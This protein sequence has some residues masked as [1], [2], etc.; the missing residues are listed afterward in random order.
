M[1][2]SRRNFLAGGAA[3]PALRQAAP[4]APRIGVVDV[5]ACFEKDRYSRM[6]ESL[7]EL[8][9]QRDLLQKEADELQ[10]RIAGLTEQMNAA[11]P[12]GDLY[13]DKLRLRTHAEYDLKLLQEVVRRK[14]RDRLTDL[15]T[16][17]YAELRRVIAQIARAQG[18]D[19]VLRVDEPRLQEEDPEAAAV[20]RN[21]SRQVLYHADALD[22]TPQV[23]ARLN[24]DWAKAWSCAACRRKVADEKCPDCGAR[25]P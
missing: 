22:L 19:L 4:A 3:L 7:L 16:R 20:Q 13:V 18:I 5:R 21:A 23:L 11:S 2:P 10:K 14:M 25:R 6:A 9:K 12:K 1:L 17:V 24:A 8:G 15:E